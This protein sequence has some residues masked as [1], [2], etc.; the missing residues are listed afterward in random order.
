MKVCRALLPALA[1]FWALL[2]AAPAVACISDAYLDAASPSF[3]YLFPNWYQTEVTDFDILFEDST[4]CPGCSD[5]DITG[6]TIVNYGTAVGG[7]AGDIKNVYVCFGCSRSS[8]GACTPA[9]TLTY[10]GIWN[11][12]S[13]T[14]PAWTWDPAAPVIL[15]ADPCNGGPGGCA[16]IFV[17][18]VFV[19]VGACPVPN[20]TV[21]L[22]PG[23]DDL[24]FDPGISDQ[25][26]CGGPYS[27]AQDASEKVIVYEAKEGDKDAAAPGDTVTYT[28][29]Y[30]R[31]GT[32]SLSDITIMD[33]QPPYTHYVQGSAVPAPDPFWDPDLGPPP[34]LKWTIPGPLPVTGGPSGRITFQ[35]TLDWGNGEGFEPGSGD[36]AAPEGYRLTNQAQAFFDGIAGC[37]V[38]TDVTPIVPTAVRRFMFWKLG[39]N[40]ILY[41]PTYGQPPDEMIYSIYIANTSTTKTWWNVT[42]WDT[43]PAELTPWCTG[44]G[45]DDP[46]TG[47]TMTPS[48]CA[49]A[50]PGNKVAAGTTLLTWKLDMPPLM[51]L[52]LRWKSQVKAT[53]SPGA[54]AINKASVLEYGRTNI[55]GGTGNSG[56]QRNF[57]H[58]API[59]LP[60]TYISYVAFAAG[61]NDKGCP[62]WFIDFFPLNKATQFELRGI[63]YMGAAQWSGLGGVSD[64]I[65]CL[66]GDCLG[67]FAGNAGCTLG[68]GAIAGGG[69]SGCKVERTPA[70][71]DPPA[72]QGT[73]PSFPFHI[74]WK[75]TS[76]SPILWQFLTHENCDCQDSHT[77]AP[78]TTITYR[79]LMHYTWRRQSPTQ[80]AGYG[81][82]MTLINTGL[83]PYGAYQATQG[84]TV[85]IF[86]FNYGT[87]SWDY[88]RT[89][90]LGPEGLAY[91]LGTN[92]TQDGAFRT[93]SSDTQLLV[94]LEMNTASSNGCCCGGCMDNFGG[95]MVT[96]ETGNAIARTGDYLYGLVEYYT[97]THKVLVGNVGAANATYEVERYV[98]DNTIAVAPM[99]SQLNGTSGTWIPVALDNVPA[100]IASALNPTVYG[101]TFNASSAAFFRVH[102]LTGGPIQ[103]H[104]G[105][106]VSGGWSGGAVLHPSVAGAG[107]GNAQT[108]TEYWL[109]TNSPNN[110]GCG[111]SGGLDETVGMD[112][113]CPKLG[114]VVQ[115]ISN[116]G[117]SARYTTNGPDECV[118]FLSFTSIANTRHVYKL[119]VLVGGAVV[120]QYQQCKVT[121]KGFTAPFVE[122]GTHYVIIAPP[123]VFSG[124]SF[125]ITVVVLQQ[126]GTTMADYCGTTSF[127]STDS[128]AKI[129]GTGMDAY[130]Y[131]WDSNDPA[132]S[133][134]AAGCANGCDNGVAIFLNVTMTKLGLQ[135]IVAIDTIDGS[136]TGVTAIMVVGA[137]VKLTKQP[138]L[139]I[140]ASGDTVQFKVCWS[141][142]SSASAFSFVMTDAVPMGTSFVP[143]AT[144]GAFN[145]GSTDG[146]TVETAYSAATTATIPAAASFTVGLPP[147]G[148]RWLR[149]TVP[150]AGI[151]TT[152]CVCYRVSVN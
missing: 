4:T 57:N 75:L 56:V 98:P 74:V 151:G 127:T 72:W 69:V 41:A 89:Y 87:L 107:A 108:G 147:L 70:Y 94:S 29:Y 78:S 62:G 131:T 50:S 11:L 82:A 102:L 45:F 86:T 52:T 99:P 125:W 112:A 28:I 46:C 105:V 138:P 55:V 119:N 33:S 3:T 61:D 68:M 113:F 58:L 140:Q 22:G 60:T 21:K 34:R 122:S 23:F 73:C 39:D 51:T 38:K 123:V 59:V 66:I 149:W 6:L 53:V 30:G 95:V 90:E 109:F 134:K 135:S 42:V 12:G 148:T 80:T 137:D 26:G 145:C 96:R 77:F 81:D 27:D 144:T 63:Q 85:H 20:R 13:N 133:C 76:N 65:G 17:M 124:S 91:T 16:C 79:G 115:C 114:Q 126:G 18:R 43:A 48:G 129:G 71:Y 101:A 116:D 24:L 67:G 152:G 32:G 92:A 120:C 128:S 146:V 2:A 111:S 25:Y 14:V 139:S 88:V 104:H 44:C 93:V 64:S 15:N 103:V 49:A 110:G 117:Y 5:G 150:M 19:D 54:T 9:Y 100:G 40:D 47:W 136:I 97:E 83:D 84:T 1:G 106:R 141:N 36:V 142:Y 8:G 10:A 37:G 7:A 35:L 130:N 121:E 143:E 132:A 31:P 118:S